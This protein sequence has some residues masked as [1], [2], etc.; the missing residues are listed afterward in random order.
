MRLFVNMRRN[1]RW[2]NYIQRLQLFISALR[3]AAEIC[4]SNL[5]GIDENFAVIDLT[6]RKNRNNTYVFGSEDL[7]VFGAPVYAGRAAS[8]PEGLF[9]N[10]EG[11]G[12]PR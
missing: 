5:R 8:L 9:R 4:G 12:L 3:A 10:L 1:K 2:I 11:N 7:V 6:D